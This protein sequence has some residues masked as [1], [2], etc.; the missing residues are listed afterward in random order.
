MQHPNNMKLKHG[1]RRKPLAVPEADDNARAWP[2]LGT[3]PNAKS[4][5]YGRPVFSEIRWGALARRIS[6]QTRK[7]WLR[8]VRA[9]SPRNSGPVGH[10]P[11][12]FPFPG[13]HER[14]PRDHRAPDEARTRHREEHSVQMLDWA[15]YCRHQRGKAERLAEGRQ[16]RV[17]SWPSECLQLSRPRQR[18]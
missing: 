11:R 12:S 18:D 14:L 17:Q 5:G 2:W 9:S 8:N 13:C 6:I 3:N 15:P 16:N 10:V 7:S 1:W 4:T